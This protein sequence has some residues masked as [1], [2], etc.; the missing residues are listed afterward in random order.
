M[1]KSVKGM[2][3]E[4]EYVL[5]DISGTYNKPDGPPILRKTKAV[6]AYR[7]MGV[8]LVLKGKGV[9]YL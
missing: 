6:P 5:V 3:G 9:Y 8:I 4:N 2:A 7:M 1:S